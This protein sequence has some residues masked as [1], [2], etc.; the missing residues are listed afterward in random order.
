MVLWIIFAG[1]SLVTLAFVCRPLLAGGAPSL[2]GSDEVIYAAQLEEIEADRARGTLPDD[3][4]EA[5]R[6]EVARR[7]LRAHRGGG[8]APSSGGR[9][10]LT[11]ALLLLIVPA[12]A[13][14]GYVAL[15]SPGY[16][17]RPLASRDA[18]GA[19]DAANLVADAERRLTADP[20][21]GEGWAAIA[22]VYLRMRRFADAADA[23][24]RA[25]TLVGPDARYLTGRGQA[26]MFAAGGT[27]T[28]EARGL[29]EQAAA[30]E[31]DAA[32][33]QVF[34]A[35]SDRQRGDMIAA[36]RRWRALLEG[37]DGSES[38]LPIA[39]AEIG[40]IQAAETARS[41]D[42]PSGGAPSTDTPSGDA[43]SNT[44]PSGDPAS[45]DFAPPAAAMGAIAAL[46]AAERAAQIG[47][48]VD[49]LAARLEA[50]GGTAAEWARLVRSYR[51]M[52]RDDEA[53]TA[54][55]SARAALTGDER[56][57]FDSAI[58]DT[59][60]EAGN[61]ARRATGAPK[62]GAD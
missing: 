50:D 6:A 51:V 8:A 60:G 35:V 61:E 15:G 37:S 1:L 2:G 57:A 7:L 10:W 23:Y 28:D 30:T 55:Q 29:F 36:A 52:G 59:A 46:P 56:S 25:I 41:G 62:A 26:L 14:A 43:P 40:E 21:D 32:A 16:G 53:E 17:D 4:A 22:P 58:R 34:L 27:V 44:P 12:G 3:E 13:A 42:T 31:P 47:A 24:Q 48:M 39:R 38:W 20:G 19:G 54:I 9:R 45:P 5:A 49:G 11:A 33:P 18:T